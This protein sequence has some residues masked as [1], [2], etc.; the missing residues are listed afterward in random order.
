MTE[1]ISYGIYNTFV[2]CCRNSTKSIKLCSPFVKAN[3]INDIYE[4]KKPK[5]D[6]DL[7]TRINIP[8][9][10]KGSIDIA[11]L[12][13]ISENG[14]KL[15]NC[16]NLHAKIY[17]FDDSQVIVTSANLTN[18][19]LRH[20]LECGIITDKEKIVCESL[21]LYDRIIDSEISSSEI[22]ISTL[23]EIEKILFGLPKLEQ[24]KYPKIK[25]TLAV[26]SGKISASLSGW[27]KD[28]FAELDKLTTVNFD[29]L[30]S[31]I[32]ADRL[33]KS[34]PQNNNREAKVRQVLQQ[35]RDLGLIEFC[36]NGKYKKLW[37]N[38]NDL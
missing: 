34:Y 27:K 15:Y 30:S 9:F 22:G 31:K 16:S 29:S 37:V 33:K 7:I 19:G 1:L 25:N 8:N 4:C 6:I 10:H 11:A 20:N 23:C 32:I 28:V 35:L 38:E 18:G 26:E 14:D 2:D 12:K 21:Y 17:I 24:L 5:T 36:G 3:I 13:T